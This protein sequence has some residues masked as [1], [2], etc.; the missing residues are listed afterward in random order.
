MILLI[1][2]Q[3]DPIISQFQTFTYF[4]TSIH[5]QDLRRLNIEPVIKQIIY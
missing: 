3:N 1:H 4:L 2:S 5:F